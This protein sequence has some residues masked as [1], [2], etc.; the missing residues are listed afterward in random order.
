MSTMLAVL[1]P[2]GEAIPIFGGDEKIAKYF[3]NTDLHGM[4]STRYRTCATNIYRTKDGRFFHLHGSMNPDPTF[5]SID[6]P[7][8]MPGTS[9]EEA[10][11]PIRERIGQMD[12]D[13]LQRKASD[14]YKQAGTICYSTEEYRASEHGKANEHVGLFEVHPYA[15][16]RQESCWWPDSPQTSSRRPLAGLKVVDLTRIIAAPAVTRG[17]AELGASVMRVTAPHVTDLCNLNCDLGWGKWTTHLDLRQEADRAKLK[18]LVMEADVVVQGYRPGV[19]DKYGFGQSD[20]IEMC[21]SRERGIISARVNCYGWHGPWSYRSGWQQ[22]SDANTG[23]SESFGAAMGLEDGEPVT[24]VFPNSDYCTGIAGV[25]GILSALL[26]RSSEGGNYAV[27]LALNYYNQWLIN[28]CGTYPQEVW[29]DVFEKNESRVFR[30]LHPMLY[31]L[32]RYYEMLRKNS[33]DRVLNPEHFEIRDAK[34]IGTNVRTVKPILQYPGGEVNLCYN[35][36]TRGN[37]VDATRWPEDLMTE[38]VK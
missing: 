27:D 37:G 15:N 28:S 35:V 26:R 11:D 34:A 10:W 9:W 19:L 8:D 30:S 20:I 1:D 18:A 4:M 3:P 38:V 5:A 25:C 22:I 12:S 17:L 23:V 29:K 16:A 33:A 7:S 24:P 6:M 13:E 36:S 2:D 14:V 31:T 32:P 21:A